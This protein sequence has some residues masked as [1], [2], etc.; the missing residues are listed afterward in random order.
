MRFSAI[1]SRVKLWV[2]ISTTEGR[3][4]TDGLN[5]CPLPVVDEIGAIDL[6]ALLT[7]S[8]RVVEALGINAVLMERAYSQSTAALRRYAMAAESVLV[9]YF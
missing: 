3:S 8:K 7:D 5:S 6:M 2:S 4:A 9:T 1:S